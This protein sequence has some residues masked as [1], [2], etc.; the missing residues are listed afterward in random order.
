[1]WQKHLW[2]RI[3]P[4]FNRSFPKIHTW[5][6]W[7]IIR[8]S[9]YIFYPIF[10]DHFYFFNLGFFFQKILSL[11]IVS[12][13]ERVLIA[14]VWYTIFHLLKLHHLNYIKSLMDF[15]GNCWEK[16]K[17]YRQLVYRAL[18]HTLFKKI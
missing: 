7:A 8:C 17:F 16:S 6:T 18:L 12:T 11:Y 1:M 10:D 9:L 14:L 4:F 15:R 3:S 5:G 2:S 13:Q